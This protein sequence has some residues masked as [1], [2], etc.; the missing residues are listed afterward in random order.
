M[1]SAQAKASAKA[2]PTS[3]KNKFNELKDKPASWKEIMS[4]PKLRAQLSQ[5]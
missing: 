1:N 4:N 5:R 3:A 2:L